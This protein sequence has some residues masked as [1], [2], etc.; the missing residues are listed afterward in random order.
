MERLFTVA[1][2]EAARA[3]ETTPGAEYLVISALQLREGSARR[4][5]ARSGADPDAFRNVVMGQSE[6]TPIS[7]DTTSKRP[8]RYGASGRA[9]FQ[10]VVNLVREERSQ[11]YAAYIVLVAAQIDHGATPDILRQIGVDRHELASAARTELDT[12]RQY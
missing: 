12:L 11:I 9:L 6:D 3:G 7:T 5:F 8:V 10:E 4:S 1:E 2:E